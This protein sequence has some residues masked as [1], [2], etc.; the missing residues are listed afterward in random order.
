MKHTN[1]FITTLATMLLVA[2]MAIGQTPQNRTNSTI[3]ADVLA[4]LPAQNQANYNN[5][6]TN[7]TST[8]EEGL[9]YLIGQ[10][11]E[12]GNKTN[13]TLDYAISGWTNF[14]SNDD[15]KRKTALAAYEKALAQPL[16]E[17]NKAMIIRQIE[18]IGDNSNVAAL[19]AFIKDPRLSGPASQALAQIG[20]EDAKQLLLSELSKTDNEEIKIT[21]ANALVQS[22]YKDA[23]NELITL[24]SNNPSEELEKII[25]DGL[26]KIG[27]QKSLE[28]LKQN[29]KK[30]N[31]AYE[32]ANATS[33][34]ISL[35][36]NL[37]STDSKLVEKEAMSLLNIANNQGQNDLMGVA[38][39]LA[40]GVASR[41]TAGKIIKLAMKSGDSNFINNV[42]SMYD[43]KK[44]PLAAT[45]IVK[46]LKPKSTSGAQIAIINWLGNQ[47]IP[48]NTSVIS[49]FLKSSN[50]DVQ[51]A[52]VSSLI[53]IGSENAILPIAKLLESND[54]STINLAKEALST[55]NGD[56]SN[57]LMP[58][59]ATSNTVGQVAALQL[60]SNRKMESKYDLVYK[61]LLSDNQTIKTE[62]AKSLKDVST[63][64][65]L[66]DLFS[67]LEQSEP[68]YVAYIQSAI[69]SVLSTIPQ[70]EQLQVVTDKMKGTDKK[71]LYYSALANSQ[72]EQAKEALTSA[73]NAESGANKK[74]AFDALKQWKT[75]DAVYTLL[76][77]A[78][79]SSDNTTVSEAVDAIVQKVA[80]SN[81]T[82]AVKYLYLR[83]AM[84]LAKTDTQKNKIIQLIGNTGSYQAMIYAAS[85]M[86][87]PSISESAAQAAMNIGTNNPQFAGEETT[88]ILNKVSKTLNN[89]DAGYQRQNI[90]KFLAENPQDG[91]YVSIFNGKNLDGW[92]GLV[93][94]P[95]SR[96]KMST[97]Q[98]ATAQLKANEQMDLDWKVEDGL[99]IFDGKGF[100]N[101]CTDKLYGDFEMLIDWKLY[102]GAEPDAGIYLRGTPQVQIWDTARVDAGAQVGSGGLYNNQNNPSKPLK[103]ADQ[104]IGEW[105]TFRIKMIGDRVWVWLNDELVTENVMLENFW[106][107]KQPIFP[108]EQIELQAH[109]SKVAYRD[110]FIKEI[111]RTEPFELSAEE[112]KEGY[113]VL[114]DGTNMHSWTGNTE[115]YILE[116]GNI[117][118][119][120]TKSFGGNLYTK[121]EFSNFVFRFEFMLTPGANNGLGIRTPMEG[122]AAYMGMELQILDNDAPIYKD[123]QVYQYHGSVYGVIAAKR[124]FLKPI[125]EWNY[126]EVIANGD[127]IKVTLNGEVIV[128]GNLK[129][130]SKN[131]TVDGKNHPGLL[132]KSGHIG[133]LG[134]GSAVKFRNVRIKELK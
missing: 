66:E 27:T 44:N 36:K 42:L 73:Y 130:A 94:N 20:S 33:A 49:E 122:D 50:K 121:D 71:Y 114:F 41:S 79:D 127:N 51:K 88:K 47:K 32:K 23:E 118:M 124:G 102:P 61:L 19:S 58:V 37:S 134:H 106:D 24:L 78:R 109:G 52:A 21:L 11:N 39:D 74:A 72:S 115:E 80:S 133:F 76:D 26:G 55:Y 97:K 34:Y 38:V 92:K 13:E 31:Y 60:I 63:T 129:E 15:A 110:I 98:L 3:I 17:E 131:G 57:M 82:G 112:K 120:P 126:Q 14:V 18:K 85:F 56:F 16:H 81:Q 40:M 25:Y 22:N 35:L 123:L 132:N 87:T 108:I 84:E 91:G 119:R 95:I 28:I 54:P 10:L 89:P 93:E 75:F 67:L 64:E 8:G 83:E 30:D 59:F 1:R 12:P 69:N 48:G 113:K 7:L 86:D 99:I 105:N 29:A 77:I 4:Q 68:D 100:D 125:G 96:A 116:E 70:N 107:R 128:E 2:S 9:L 53:K 104:K 62:A 43:F 117:V 45:S 46:S 101:L 111:E 6:M 5:M 103:V 90:S 65:N